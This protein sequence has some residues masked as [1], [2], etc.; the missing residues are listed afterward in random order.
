MKSIKSRVYCSVLGVAFCSSSLVANST[1]RPEDKLLRQFESLIVGEFDNYNQVN[2]ETNEFLSA[3][4]VP[5]Q[6]H[7][8]LY[9]R[10]AKIHA[11]QLGEYVFYEQTHSGGKDKKIYR[12]SLLVMQAD[13]RNNR[14]VARNYKFKQPADFQNLWDAPEQ[15]DLTTADLNLV[16]ENC[17]TV[18]RQ[19]GDSFVG[20][21]DPKTC[22]VESKHG[23][24]VMIGSDSV[25]SQQGYWH[26][27]AGFKP[28]GAM[29]FGRKDQDFYKLLRANPFKCWFA[30]KTDRSKENGEPEWDF[31]A[32]QFMHS[33]GDIVRFTT[34]H[35]QPEKYFVRLKET[36]FPS[37]KRP[38]VLEMFVHRD[39]EKAQKDYK[40]ALSYS[41]TSIEADRLGIN[42][43]WMQGS[44]SKQP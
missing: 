20:K 6:K 14:L 1:E 23:G 27:E 22:A 43:R 2:F 37:G 15:G 36:R 11:P 28:D 4:D 17:E 8:R 41:W 39:T 34:T 38:D 21:I 44:C 33:Q 9:K 31:Y 19:L 3:S 7:A 16:G 26:L 40:Q 18:F 12:Q 24:K 25:I 42:L 29:I 13:Y 35:K 32:N 5:E 10:V 30:F